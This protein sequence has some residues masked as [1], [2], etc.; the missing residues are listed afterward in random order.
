[1][2]TICPGLYTPCHSW[3][4]LHS[5]DPSQSTEHDPK[6]DELGHFNVK[7]H[8]SLTHS[9]GRSTMAHNKYALKTQ[10]IDFEKLSSYF[11]W[12]NKHTIEKPSTKPLNG[13]LSPLGIP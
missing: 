13:L 7:V 12:V 2:G 8:H 10:P 6:I 5:P 11:G 4:P 9:H 3:G 1:M